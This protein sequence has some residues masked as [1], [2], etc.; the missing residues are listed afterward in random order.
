MTAQGDQ[1]KPHDPPWLG[2]Q[3][4]DMLAD[5][6]VLKILQELSAGAMRPNEA[7]HRLPSLSHA[8]LVRRLG[9][10][11]QQGALS[12]QRASTVP[13]GSIYSLTPAGQL[14]VHIAA[15]AAKWEQRWNLGREPRTG[16]LALSVL[17]DQHSVSIIH[18][19]ADAPLS[20]RE[21][22]RR[23][24]AT[25]HATLMRRLRSLALNGILDR[26]GSDHKVSYGLADASRHLGLLLLLAV[27][28]EWT[29][30]QPDTPRAN[31]LAV[32]LHLTSTIVEIPPEL[33]GL[34]HIHVDA[35]RIQQ[36]DLYLFADR[37]KLTIMDAPHE[38]RAAVSAHATPAGWCDAL[39]GHRAP[40][41]TVT[42]DRQLLATVLTSLG[43][44][45]TA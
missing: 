36:I 2:Y 21:L 27:Q 13:P 12:R 25:K 11:R 19:L 45:I 38:Q 15:Q 14:L 16:E 28:W 39:L 1:T 41:G 3:A 8:G 23:L 26:R 29:S 43:T 4:L 35:P 34:C 7:D 22:G 37:G 9:R 18:R 32:L 20:P 44:I 40:Q 10:L 17:A 6:G 5:N 30:Q 42:G 31:T 33:T 24:P